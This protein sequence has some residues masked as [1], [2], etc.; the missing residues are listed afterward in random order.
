MD[1]PCQDNTLEVCVIS[2]DEETKKYLREYYNDCIHFRY[3]T[4]VDVEVMCPTEIVVPPKAL[5]FIVNT[6]IK[7]MFLTRKEGVYSLNKEGVSRIYEYVA[8]GIYPDLEMTTI[9]PVRLTTYTIIMD[10]K[11]F[12]KEI[13]LIYDNLSDEPYT[14]RRGDR[15]AKIAHPS[16]RYFDVK[17]VDSLPK[18]SAYSDTLR[19]S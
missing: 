17:V 11:H 13:L 12:S 8:Y 10:V 4:S 15:L 16:F 6:G 19:K 2:E 7:A 18:F 14:I 1:T 3:P 5:G 9:T